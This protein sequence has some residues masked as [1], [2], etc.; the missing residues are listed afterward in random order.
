M[1]KLF[2]ILSLLLAGCHAE[3]SGGS[4]P[5]RLNSIGFLPGTSKKATIIQKCSGF[6]LKRA[7]DDE[8]VFSGEV[9]GPFHQEDVNQDA[10]VADFSAFADTGSYYLEVPGVG[11][12]VTF[13]ISDDVFRFPYVTTMRAFY[14]WRCGTAVE[15]DFNGQHFAHAACHLDDGYCDYLDGK[16]VIRKGTK[17]WHDAGD[18]GKYTVNAGITMGTLFLAWEQFRPTLEKATLGLPE[19]APGFPEY[20][21]EL[22]WETDW[23][24]TMQYPDGSGRVSHKLTRTNFAGFVRPEDDKGKRYFTEWSST[25]TA[26][27]VAAMAMA[28]RNFQPYDAAYA[29]TCLDAAEKSYAFLK[30]HPEMKPFEQGDFTTGAYKGKSDK[31]ERLWAAVELWETTGNKNYL[32]DFEKSAP[33]FTPRIDSDWDWQN[34]KNLAMFTYALSKREGRNPKLAATIQQAILANADLLVEKGKQDIYGRPLGSRYYWGCNGTVAR[35]AVNLQVAN[36]ISPNRAYTN[37]VVSI[38]DHL[39]GRNVYDRSYITGLGYQPPMHPHDRNSGS[40]NIEQPWPGYLVG[41]GRTATDWQ[42]KQSDYTTN[43]IAIN[44]QAALVYALAGLVD[45]H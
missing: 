13:R 44:W 9:T 40:D 14:L 7:T 41:G 30:K 25:A 43:E 3:A 35:Q 12:S 39:L 26:D 18:Y 27:F 15:G 21:E 16:G 29:K 8:K 4:F 22:K 20:L 32:E 5:V 2:V 31:D 37:T 1:K 45:Q 11:R 19:T 24:L 34:V 38:V 17:G 42:D 28:A 23:L 6:E 10:W 36:A 33:S